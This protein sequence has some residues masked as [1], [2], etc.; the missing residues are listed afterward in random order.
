MSVDANGADL[1]TGVGTDPNGS[2]ALPT[3]SGDGRLV[4]FLSAAT[5]LTAMDPNG[6]TSDI[7]VRDLVT[8]T[9][10]RA[11]QGVNPAVGPEKFSSQPDLSRDGRFVAFTSE[12]SDIVAGDTNGAFDIFIRDLVGGTTVRATVD[13]V[14]GQADGPS[15]APALDAD[16][17]TV[18]FHSLANDLV[19]GDLT[20]NSDV[21]VRDL[22]A[23]QNVRASVSPSGGNADEG[24]SDPDLDDR[25]RLVTF[26]GSASN[27][28]AGDANGNTHDVFVRDLAAG[29]TTLASVS[30]A[31]VQGNN[32]SAFPA[33]SGDGTT[34]AFGSNASN[35]VPGDGNAMND[36][37][38]REL[39]AAP[40]AVIPE[41]PVAWL[42]P[43]AGLGLLAVALRRRPTA[44]PDA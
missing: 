6:T 35:L 27:L 29:Q 3:I 22:V 28:V 14:G 4:G 18:A 20:S 7:Y 17:S 19:P 1:V 36:V 10:V 13:A 5:N 23:R 32:L 9:T 44:R 21:F 31:G 38:A 16:G 15:F 8:D 11:S 26:W 2:S 24:T 37:F 39:P 43:A 30:G 12:A 41:V 33:I 42:L 25:G 40:A 34:V